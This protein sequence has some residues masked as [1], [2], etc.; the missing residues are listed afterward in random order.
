MDR[1]RTMRRA[2]IA[3]LVMIY[4][5]CIT[6]SLWRAS[7]PPDY[8]IDVRSRAAEEVIELWGEP[9]HVIDLDSK[10]PYCTFQSKT[11]MQ[12]LVYQGPRKQLLIS[13]DR[14]VIGVM[15]LAEV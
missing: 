9:D 1:S 14:R 12:K 3:T 13:A 2:S 15:P 11:V 10:G 4:L 6:L 7:P 5:G 8:S